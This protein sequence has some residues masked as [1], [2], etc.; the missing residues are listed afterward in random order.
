MTRVQVLS[1][2]DILVPKV[3]YFSTRV[4]GTH[5]EKKNISSQFLRALPVDAGGSGGGGGGREE[6]LCVAAGGLAVEAQA[7]DKEVCYI[8]ICMYTYYVCRERDINIY[9]YIC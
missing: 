1:K 5:R 3:R 7:K 2:L 9:I 8:S 4:G 6:G